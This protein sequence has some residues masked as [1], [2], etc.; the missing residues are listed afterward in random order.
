[1]FIRDEA[2]LAVSFPAAAARL[3]DLARR[4]RLMTA[5]QDAFQAGLARLEAH[6]APAP[7]VSVSGLARARFR[8]LI[9]RGDAADLALR[10]EAHGPGG[11]L[12]PALDADVTLSP[13]GAAATLLALAGVYRVPAGEPGRGLDGAIVRHMAEETTRTFVSLMAAAITAARSGSGSGHGG[14]TDG[15][16]WPPAFRAP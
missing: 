3:A 11:E 4:G 15:G 6:P 13:D 8:E 16:S 10:W 1:M 7:A 9:V 12:F 14:I 5:S 2:R